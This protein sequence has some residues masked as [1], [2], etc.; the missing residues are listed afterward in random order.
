MKY[1]ILVIT[2]VVLAFSCK[3]EEETSYD[4]P[5]YSYNSGSSYSYYYFKGI[6]KDTTNNTS[7]KNHI[8]RRHSGCGST[9]LTLT[10]STYLLRNKFG[11]NNHKNPCG[12]D[13]IIIVIQ[14][15]VGNEINSR[16]VLYD[17]WKH[18]DTINYDILF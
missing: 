13:Y 16:S 3:K 12:K 10:D 2:V 14:D 8:L 18:N 5:T 4:N 15:S 6:V 1:L 17:N 9:S 7:L 11:Y